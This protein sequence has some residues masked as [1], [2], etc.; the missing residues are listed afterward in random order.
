LADVEHPM[1]KDL[2]A[3]LR[4]ERI[5]S[6]PALEEIKDKADLYGINL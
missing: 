3:M 1:M 2:K 5:E 4:G 6:Y